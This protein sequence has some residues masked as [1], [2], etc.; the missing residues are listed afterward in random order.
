VIPLAELARRVVMRVGLKRLLGKIAGPL[1]LTI[2]DATDL[3]ISVLADL[4][5]EADLNADGDGNPAN[6]L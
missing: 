1:G 5:A 6:P 4:K 2:T 3:A